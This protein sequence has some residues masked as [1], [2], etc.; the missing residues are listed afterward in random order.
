MNEMTTQSSADK[1]PRMAPSKIYNFRISAEI[2]A[3]IDAHTEA[4]KAV[5]AKYTFSGE[6]LDKLCKEILQ[7]PD[8]IETV[9]GP[10]RPVVKEKT[11]AKK[12]ST[13]KKPREKGD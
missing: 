9:P 5:N 4:R 12:A 3:A 6:L 7:Q 2:R 13:K 1:M 10:G 8:L 11:P